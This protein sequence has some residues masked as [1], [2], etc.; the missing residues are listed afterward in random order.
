MSRCLSLHSGER[1]NKS[2]PPDILVAI[3]HVLNFV[4]ISF[5][6]LPSFDGFYY[7]PIMSARHRHLGLA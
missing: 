5:Y 2:R 3:F 7:L 6:Y 4:L 1:R